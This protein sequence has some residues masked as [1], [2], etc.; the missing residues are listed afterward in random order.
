MAASHEAVYASHE[1]VSASHEA[2]SAS[3][4]AV[5]ASHEAV[6]A[7]HEAV[8]LLCPSSIIYRFRKTLVKDLYKKN[9]DRNS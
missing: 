1:A 9:W 8:F 5:S 4:E 2:V 3:H 7:S 6:S